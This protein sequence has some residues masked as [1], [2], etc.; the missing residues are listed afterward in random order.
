MEYE[1]LYN[2]DKDTLP[3]QRVKNLL[4]EFRKLSRGSGI[5]AETWRK[6]KSLPRR[7]ANTSTHFSYTITLEGGHYGSFVDE[8]TEVK[9]NEMTCPGSDS[10]DVYARFCAKHL[11]AI[12][13]TTTL[14]FRHPT[15]PRTDITAATT[16]S[17]LEFGN[18]LFLSSEAGLQSQ[19]SLTPKIN[20]RFCK[21][22]LNY[23]SKVLG[24]KEKWL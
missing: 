10:H 22:F 9:I 20:S 23:V 21:S 18:I 2:G 7:L 17:C 6:R 12:G 3:W 14:W 16:G 5:W 24:S 15:F 4:K 8:K 1:V 13:L 11:T 19:L